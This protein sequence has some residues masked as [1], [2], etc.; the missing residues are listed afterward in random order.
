MKIF[1]IYAKSISSNEL[2]STVS[3]RE[4]KLKTKKPEKVNNKRVLL[5]TIKNIGDSI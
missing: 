3:I 1:Q 4:V 2:V 5:K